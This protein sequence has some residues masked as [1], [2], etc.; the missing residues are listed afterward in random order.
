MLILTTEGEIDEALLV[1]T[2]GA[3]DDEREYTTFVE[4]RRPG[5]DVVIHRS[6][7]V[8]LKQGLEGAGQQTHFDVDAWARK[9]VDVLAKRRIETGQPVELE[10]SF[11][12]Q[13][14][15]AIERVLASR[16]ELVG[17]LT[18]R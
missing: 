2:E 12:A 16:P 5:S 18:E 1:K 11:T 13:E 17:S 15:A 9:L 8:T 6:V 4:Y 14:R 7:H 3:V 10:Q